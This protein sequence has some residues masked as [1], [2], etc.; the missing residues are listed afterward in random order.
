MSH[1]GTE[2]RSC[3]KLR[4]ASQFAI[5][6][7]SIVG[8]RLFGRRLI[9]YLGLHLGDGELNPCS[10]MPFPFIL[11]TTSAFS[12]SSCIRCD[13]HP[14]L[15]IQASTHRGVVREALKRHKRL[16][17]S[18]Q[19]S[20][21]AT[22]VSSLNGYI[23]HL[24]AIDNGLR[25]KR[26]ATGESLT[27]H[28]KAT[29]TIEWRPTLSGEA[30]PGKERARVKITSFEHE[31]L[32]VLSTLAC[33]HVLMARSTLQPLYA[34][35][36]DYLGAQ[37]RIRAV[38]TA[39][40]YLLDAAS[41]W[42]YLA[43]RDEQAP[44]AFPCVDIATTTL[45]ALASLT[46]AEATLLAVLKDDP[47]P[48]AVAQERNKNDKDWMFKA[49]DIPK[50]RAHLYARLCLA[51]SEHGAEAASS[52]QS[53]GS[54]TSKVSPSLVR[55][56]DDLRMTSRA[57]ACRFFGIDAELG[58]NTAEGIGW[59]RAG[60]HELGVEVKDGSKKG[61]S[62]NRFRRDASEKREDRRVDKDAAWGAD[63]GRLEETRII[64]RLDLKW[65]KINDTVSSP[66]LLIFL[67]PDLMPIR[68]R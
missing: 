54:S 39:T 63:A 34:T 32:F 52:C 35:S 56:I 66:L 7:A 60:L 28:L 31:V 45:R 26:L 51:A 44:A 17:P 33:S 9:Q 27:I 2:L 37:E 21:L 20:H 36:T 25:D 59:L 15:P 30:I 47:Y 14:S 46:T 4:R 13:S 1:R 65:N 58:G 64:E 22:V 5:V 57:K 11:P 53:S 16:P 24:L 62:L 43:S 8:R 41:I 10:S 6:N 23:P 50:V 40:R 68:A 48:A 42:T 67:T 61:L 38:T 55:Y 3:C 29:P 18:S 19:A 12:F 49:P